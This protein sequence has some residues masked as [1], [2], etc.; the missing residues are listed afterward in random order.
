MHVEFRKHYSLNVHVDFYR[1]SFP[2]PSMIKTNEHRLLCE[3]YNKEIQETKIQEINVP[4]M[5]LGK[6]A[7]STPKENEETKTSKT[8]KTHISVPPKRPKLGEN[9]KLDFTALPSD[10]NVG[11]P[12]ASSSI[13]SP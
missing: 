11:K 4:Q 10:W 8:E 9:E 3:L 7:H 13:V 1:L 5:K 6:E 2:N 12:V